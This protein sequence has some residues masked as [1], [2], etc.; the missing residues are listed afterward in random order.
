MALIRN[1]CR[2]ELFI[3][4]FNCFDLILDDDY[5]DDGDDNVSSTPKDQ[6]L[7]VARGNILLYAATM[8]KFVLVMCEK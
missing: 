2:R 8:G 7:F 6:G 4:N 1:F 3:Y 5:D